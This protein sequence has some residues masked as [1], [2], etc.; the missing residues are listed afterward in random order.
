M[1][2]TLTAEEYAIVTTLKNS[3]RLKSKQAAV[4]QIIKMYKE[5]I[6]S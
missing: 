2:L 1:N 4:K 6:Q 3:M 5:L